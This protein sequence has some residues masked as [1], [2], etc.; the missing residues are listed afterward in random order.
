MT[1][2]SNDVDLFLNIKDISKDYE[3]NNHNKNNDDDNN[4]NN[5]NNGNYNNSNNNKNFIDECCNSLYPKSYRPFRSNRPGRHPPGNCSE[6]ESSGYISNDNYISNNN[7]NNS[8]LN[9]NSSDDD[10]MDNFMNNISD[11]EDINNLN[12]KTK[13]KGKNKID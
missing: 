13:F 5:N 6:D 11:N 9:D 2:N 8:D 7:Y 12:K 4:P 3:N 1:T 10:F